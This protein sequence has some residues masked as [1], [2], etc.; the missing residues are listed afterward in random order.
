MH[1]KFSVNSGRPPLPLHISPRSLRGSEEGPQRSLRK[2]A[3]RKDFREQ[4]GV[5]ELSLSPLP[6]KGRRGEP[7]SME[8]GAVSRD[9]RRMMGFQE[10][11]PAWLN[12]WEPSGVGGVSR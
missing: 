7:E 4:E 6:R 9:E 2:A 12:G 11:R 1:P 8:R 5:A 10:A 3:V